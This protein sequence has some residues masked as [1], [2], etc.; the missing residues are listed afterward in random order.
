MYTLGDDT[1]TVSDDTRRAQHLHTLAVA[2]AA[3]KA[4]NDPAKVATILDQFQT[5]SDQ[6]KALGAQL[7]FTSS[8]QLILS[9]Q[10]W[11]AAA[12]RAAANAVT[13]G[14]QG[15]GTLASGLETSLLG[16]L[17]VPALIVLGGLYLWTRRR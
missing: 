7:D 6:Y 14:V 15:V 16:P 3:A 10:Q 1:A 11:L 17:I 4:A 13:S 8:D 5:A 9:T 12:A 2:L